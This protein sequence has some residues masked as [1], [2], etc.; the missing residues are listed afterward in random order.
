M[1]KKKIRKIFLNNKPLNADPLMSLYKWESWR[2]LAQVK[3]T[4][5][6]KL[7]KARIQGVLTGASLSG[8][9]ATGTNSR[10]ILR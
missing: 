4:T 9:A 7:P 5:C 1:R 8:K 3:K 10:V 6:R 2:R